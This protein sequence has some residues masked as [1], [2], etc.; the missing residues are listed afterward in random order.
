M[1]AQLHI[2]YFQIDPEALVDTTFEPTILFS[3]LFIVQFSLHQI[4]NH[5]TQLEREL[6]CKGTIQMIY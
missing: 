5:K 4:S 1:L 6:S 2:S 3:S